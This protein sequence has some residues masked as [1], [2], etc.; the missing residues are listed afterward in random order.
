MRF[1]PTLF[2]RPLF[3]SFSFSLSPCT[4]TTTTTLGPVFSSKRMAGGGGTPSTERSW[5]M[6]PERA[7]LGEMGDGGEG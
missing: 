5:K 2:G 3:L 6:Q 4:T 7:G 1:S